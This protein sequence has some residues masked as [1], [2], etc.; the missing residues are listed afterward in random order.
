[1]CAVG[2]PAPPPA[3]SRLRAALGNLVSAER[4]D[5]GHARRIPRMRAARPRRSPATP[6]N[7]GC[8]PASRM[9]SRCATLS[10]AISVAK[11]SAV[12]TR[13]DYE[14]DLWWLVAPTRGADASRWLSAEERAERARRTGWQ[15]RRHVWTRAFVRG[16]LAGYLDRP[17]ASLRL[18]RGPHGKPELDEAGSLRFNV[19]HSSTILAV[20]VTAGTEIGVDVELVRPVRRDAQLARRWF[21]EADAASLAAAPADR[22]AR[23]FMELWTRRE[24]IAKL[25]GDGL[26]GSSSSDPQ[27]A[28]LGTS[29][30]NVDVAPGY[31]TAVALTGAPRA[32]RVLSA[33]PQ[34]SALLVG[35][36]DRARRSSGRG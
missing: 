15:R 28:T 18:V 25:S 14:V 27:S 29:V 32:V 10:A 4:S 2:A 23:R 36:R 17:P 35:S 19:S 16:V 12:A 1:M 26:C 21:S 33:F 8:C 31:A 9:Y 24:A 11:L 3:V 34:R 7:R 13:L 20:A 22:R 30:F 6:P 5:T